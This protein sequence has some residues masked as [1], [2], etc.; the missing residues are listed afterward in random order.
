[1][2]N[3]KEFKQLAD[4]EVGEIGAENKAKISDLVDAQL[5]TAQRIC[6]TNLAFDCVAQ[7]VKMEDL[8]LDIGGARLDAG[9]LIAEV[10]KIF[11]SAVDDFKWE[12]GYKA[13]DFMRKVLY[14]IGPDTRNVKKGRD[15][16]K[17]WRIRNYE[18]VTPLQH[19]AV[20]LVDFAGISDPN[21]PNEQKEELNRA[22]ANEIIKF[23]SKIKVDEGSRT[24]GMVIIS[25]YKNGDAPTS[26][27]K[28]EPGNVLLLTVKQ[29]TIVSMFILNKFTTVAC[30][31]GHDI[32]TPLAGAIFSRDSISKMMN[33]DVIKKEF[34]KKCALIDAINKS[35]QNGGQFLPGSRADIAAACVVV[36]TSG[37]KKP[38]ERKMIVQRT[39]KQFLNQKRPARKDIFNAVA[40]YA[41]GGVPEEWSFD[42]VTTEYA[43]IRVN[44]MALRRAADQTAVHLN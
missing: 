3:V 17:N 23:W 30:D 6:N 7:F 12:S 22:Y 39:I 27:P 31:K 15:A 34:V 43:N 21:L 20:K 38:E 11:P 26:Q 42:A 35:A 40:A 32:L 19:E 36:G 44:A 4:L 13:L 5:V 1:M 2:A 9:A 14:L 41:T 24:N 29:A 28:L 10:A 8:A 37:V 25:T 16:D 18:T 33:N